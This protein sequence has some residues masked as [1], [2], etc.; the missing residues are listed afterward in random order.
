MKTSM[1][2]PR[3]DKLSYVVTR[4]GDRLLDDKGNPLV[5][6]C[7]GAGH[8][9]PATPSPMHDQALRPNHRKPDATKGWFDLWRNPR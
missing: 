4:D 9:E 5:T 1:K 2:T 3:H 8:N 7:R 6:R